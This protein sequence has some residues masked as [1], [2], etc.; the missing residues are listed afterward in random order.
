MMVL[1]RFDTVHEYDRQVNRQNGNCTYRAAVYMRSA[2][3][4]MMMMMMMTKVMITV[5]FFR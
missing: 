2:V 5:M 4:M 1:S 3:E